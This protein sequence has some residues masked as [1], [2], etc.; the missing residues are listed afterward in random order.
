MTAAKAKI[1][2]PT[3]LVDTREQRPYAFEGRPMM[4]R[5]LD[6]GDYTLQG[7]EDQFAVE[8]KELG[9]FIS[10]M[11]NKKDCENRDRFE[12][13]LERASNKLRRLWILVETTPEDIKKG[14]F[15]SQ[16]RVKAVEATMLAWLNRYDPVRI[17][18]G[19]NR[20]EAAQTAEMLLERSYRDWADGKIKCCNSSTL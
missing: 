11:I 3:I 4:I 2:L 8:R 20:A 16:I 17:V 5:K 10:C 19:G 18:F 7:F 13:E 1:E 9:D 6:I 14:T 15:R 12:R